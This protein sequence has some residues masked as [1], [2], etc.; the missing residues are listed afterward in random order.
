MAKRKEQRELAFVLVF[1]HCVTGEE[2][3]TIIENAAESRD[4]KVGEFGK[5]LANGTINNL[6]KIDE[7]ISANIRKWSI[8]RL[9]KITLSILRLAVYE[10]LFEKDVPVSVSINEAVELSKMYGDAK[11]A[12]YINGVLSSV[13]KSGVACEKEDVR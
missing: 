13:E 1:E 4:V 12:S 6:E 2:I 8:N 9:P 3:D 5:R 7:I 10:L 11:D